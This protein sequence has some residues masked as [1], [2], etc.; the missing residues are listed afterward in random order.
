MVERS[1][2]RDC[3]RILVTGAGGLLG[4]A[5]VSE[6]RDRFPGSELLTP[7]R[8]ELDLQMQGAVEKYWREQRPDAVFHLAAF[9]LG[10]G[11]NLAAGA[12]AFAVNAQINHNVLMS[13]LAV[14]PKVLFAAGTVAS[15]KYPYS[16]LPLVE[17]DAFLDEPHAGEYFYG[18]A[19]RASWPYVQAVARS[20]RASATMGLFTN[21]YGPG[22][23][24]NES[25]GHVVPS[26][27]KRFVDAEVEKLP[28]VMVW[29]RPDTTRDFLFVNDAVKGLLAA[30]DADL[31]LCNI[32]SGHETTMGEL[33]DTIVR[34]SG[35]GGRVFWDETK[36]TG[37]PR[38]WVDNSRLLKAA[39]DIKFTTLEGGVGQTVAWYREHVTQQRD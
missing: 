3:S 28:E 32:S 17:A 4:K 8:V 38:R 13:C 14:P 26:L 37:I 23:N 9:V 10:L 15:Y 7:R 5:L 20:S 33:V 1:Q 6:L 11:G 18:L 25:S 30:V 39:P 19:K 31:Q 16:R 35:F 22:D 12:K 2:L 21:L 36:P 29:G 24:F 27:V 34:T